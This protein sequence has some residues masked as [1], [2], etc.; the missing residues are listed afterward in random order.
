MHFVEFRDEYVT[1][2]SHVI[3]EEKTV[4]PNY[5]VVHALSVQMI[6]K[7]T[8]VLRS[9]KIRASTIERLH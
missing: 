9:M 7:C 1:Y 4:K 3:C 2:C 5:G 6:C 8:D